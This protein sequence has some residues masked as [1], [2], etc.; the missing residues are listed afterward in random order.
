MWYRPPRL[1]D[2]SAH[3]LDTKN[4]AHDPDFNEVVQQFAN[5]VACRWDDEV[6]LQKVIATPKSRRAHYAGN[7][8]GAS[9]YADYNPPSDASERYLSNHMDWTV[10]AE[11][12]IFPPMAG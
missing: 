10:A 4:L 11:R 6:L 7:E 8:A 9:E 1:Y 5:E 2:L 12:Y 3:P